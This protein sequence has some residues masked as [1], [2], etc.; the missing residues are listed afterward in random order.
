MSLICRICFKGEINTITNKC[1][2]TIIE[3]NTINKLS[4]CDTYVHKEC[5]QNLSLYK[6]NKLY[7]ENKESNQ[8]MSVESL[9]KCIYCNNRNFPFT[10][11]HY[12]YSE[13]TLISK[14]QE[15]SRSMIIMFIAM[16]LLHIGLSL[17]GGT[18]FNHVTSPFLLNKCHNI[19]DFY[20]NASN[21]YNYQ[22]CIQEIKDSPFYTLTKIMD[23]PLILSMI[24]LIL[25]ISSYI[26]FIR[27]SEVIIDPE[28]YPL[29]RFLGKMLKVFENI[30]TR[31]YN[32][33]SGKLPG[34]YYYNP[35]NSLSLY[36]NYLNDLERYITRKYKKFAYITLIYFLYNFG[37]ALSLINYLPV[38]NYNKTKLTDLDDVKAFYKRYST[39]E[40]L[41]N[42]VTVGGFV[43]GIYVV[44]YLICVLIMI[45]C[46]II[47]LVK[48]VSKCSGLFKNITGNTKVEYQPFLN[49]E[50]ENDSL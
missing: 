28:Y 20:M 10:L 5:Y 13:N 47:D 7:T 18:Y 23:Y 9:S 11:T 33:I 2:K 25:L 17:V 4:C 24:S 16:F 43:V 22:T 48:K 29:K 45:I 12:S 19:S 15:I 26:F 40:A 34:Q 32:E 39:T 50:N 44:Y 3:K 27:I 31:I 37:H 14:N 49:A 35:K 41:F 38:E 21:I 42:I 46:I 6:R 1:C 36:T 30:G 8:A